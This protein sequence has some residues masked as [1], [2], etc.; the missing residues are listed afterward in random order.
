MQYDYDY[1]K[2]TMTKIY[3]ELSRVLTAYE[4]G[5]TEIPIDETDL[6]DLCIWTQNQLEGLL[7]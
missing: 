3:D 2:I 5:E 4:T 6:Y 7:N 1:E